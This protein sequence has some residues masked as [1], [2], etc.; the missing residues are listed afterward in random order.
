MSFEEFQGG[1]LAVILDIETEPNNFRVWQEMS[2]EEF[3]DG[4]QGLD[5]G[6]E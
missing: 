5:I 2:F 6:M 4:H 1:R 3:Q